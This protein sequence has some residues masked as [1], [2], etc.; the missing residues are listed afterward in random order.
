MYD[1]VPANALETEGLGFWDLASK[2]PSSFLC[3]AAWKA[4]MMVGPLA[5]AQSWAV[6]TAQLNS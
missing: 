4:A 2:D 3:P 5:L 6:R 1:Q